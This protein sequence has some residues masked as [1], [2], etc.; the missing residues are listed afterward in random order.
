MKYSTIHDTAECWNVS[1]RSVRNYCAQGRVEG[2]YR[3]GRDWMIP[4][5]AAKPE[6]K[7]RAGKLPNTLIK[8]L[9]EEQA[10][11]LSGGIYHRLQIDF[12]ICQARKQPTFK[13]AEELRF[14]NV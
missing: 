9:R 2:A 8:W 14:N 5:G 6:R 7:P 12:T 1:E 3:D 10:S 13:A 11:G 4:A